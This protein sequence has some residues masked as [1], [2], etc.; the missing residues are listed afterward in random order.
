M[1]P[2][3]YYKGEKIKNLDNDLNEIAGI[4][5]RLNFTKMQL[6]KDVKERI[7]MLGHCICNDGERSRNTQ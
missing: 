6:D 7:E 2:T 4:V 3:S 5:G 1:Y